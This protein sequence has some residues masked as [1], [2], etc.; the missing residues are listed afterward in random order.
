MFVTWPGYKLIG[1]DW[2]IVFL[3]ISLN[4]LTQIRLIL[5]CQHA[6]HRVSKKEK[7]KPVGLKLLN[8]EWQLERVK[9]A[10][11]LASQLSKFKF[12]AVRNLF[13]PFFILA[14]PNFEIFCLKS[15]V[16]K[17]VILCWFNEAELPNAVCLFLA[18]GL[19]LFCFEIVFCL[20]RIRNFK[21]LREGCLFIGISVEVPWRYFYE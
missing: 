16:T 9:G 11:S 4:C 21:S 8:F 17:Y 14:S 5:S 3:L 10:L 12:K 1:F 15:Q 2:L 19:L 6:A 20:D 13:Y 7:S 18:W